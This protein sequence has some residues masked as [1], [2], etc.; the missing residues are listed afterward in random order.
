MCKSCIAVRV[1]V[2]HCIAWRGG[3]SS[4]RLAALRRED[5]RW[6]VEMVSP[7]GVD[8]LGLQLRV[9]WMD[10][11]M[12]ACLIRTRGVDGLGDWQPDGEGVVWVEDG[13]RDV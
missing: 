2:V 13:Q 9:A 12:V 6:G 5:W 1:G 7:C 3:T 11:D 10:M 4:T 8:L